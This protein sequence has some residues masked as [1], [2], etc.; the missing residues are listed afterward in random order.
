MN[1]REGVR[2]SIGEWVEKYRRYSYE[3]LGW[4]IDRWD[5][6]L[7]NRLEKQLEKARIRASVGQYLGMSL[8]AIISIA[9]AIFLAS[10]VTRSISDAIAY[11]SLFVA[12]SAFMLIT[13]PGIK[14]RRRAKRIDDEL[15]YAFGYM[16]ALASSGMPP[17]GIFE[18]L[19]SE[20]RIY[21]EMGEE[22]AYIVRDMKVFGMDSISALTE[23]AKRSPSPTLSA[24]LHTIVASLLAG[25]DL[26]SILTEVSE[27][28]LAERRLALR[29]FVDDMAIYSEFYVV[30]CILAPLFV[31]IMLP[32]T[33]AVNM[34]VGAQSE[35]SR[36]MGSNTVFLLTIYVG[37]PLLTLFFLFGIE[38]VMPEDIRG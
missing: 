17:L 20:R 10:S 36:L 7:K 32:V 25:S 22:A 30:L 9:I 16:S 31:L 3:L 19:A 13:F 4:R 1:L 21:R 37:V 38:A 18:A 6:S 12:A 24:L 29:G 2:D 26:A 5:W 14:V 23:A 28:R 33:S 15:P 11:A 35:I 34:L 8:L 27:Q